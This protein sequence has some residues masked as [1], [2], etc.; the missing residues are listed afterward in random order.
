MSSQYSA[1]FQVTSTATVNA[2][3]TANGMTASSVASAAYTISSGMF[4]VKADTASLTI[5]A[6]AQATSTITVAPSSGST[7][8]NAVALTCAVTGAGTLPTCSVSP[9]SVTPGA[10]GATSTLT[11]SVPASAMVLNSP[12]GNSR[13]ISDWPRIREWKI[14]GW[15]S[16]RLAFASLLAIVLSTLLASMRFQRKLRLRYVWLAAAFFL[17]ILQTACG[18]GGG[19][20]TAPPESTSQTYTVTITGVSMSAN[21]VKIQQTATISVTVP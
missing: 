14:V 17:A 3:A 5:N 11:V 10:Q 6:G 2:F 16:S 18:G 4:T 12:S 21:S 19:S 8:S 20:T 13:R 1:A 9:S 15:S 7:F